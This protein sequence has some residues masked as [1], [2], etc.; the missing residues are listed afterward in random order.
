MANKMRPLGNKVVVRKEEPKTKSA[1]GIL[2]PDM[3]VA[4]A[5]RQTTR[6]EVL[7]VGPGKLNDDGVF[8]AMNVKAGDVVIFSQWG[9]SEVEVDGEKYQLMSEDDIMAVLE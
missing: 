3:T 6:G 4:E 2:L 1:G 7:A 9:G 8:L 5:K